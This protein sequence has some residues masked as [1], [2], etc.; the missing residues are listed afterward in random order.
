MEE[1]AAGKGKAPKPFMTGKAARAPTPTRSGIS[2]ATAARCRSERSRQA[3][4]AV[5][6]AKAAAR[7]RPRP[8]R[9]SSRRSSAKLVDRPPA[10]AGWAHEIK[11]DGY[12][13][14]LRVEDGEATL[15]TRKGL[16]WTDK[17]RRHRQRGESAA[18]LHHRRRDRARSTT[19]A[20][21]TSPP[22]RRRSPSGKTDD[23]VFFVFDLLFAD[24]EDL[25]ALPLRE[26]KARLQALLDGDAPKQ[27]RIRYVEHFE[28]G[29]DAVLQ[30][31]C[32]MSLEGIVSKR[33]ERPIAPAAATTGRKPS[34]APATRW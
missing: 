2:N 26:R 30:S 9:T 31:A 13:L 19:T 8:C 32:R 29:G 23:L 25:R 34:A 12:R 6:S 18:R 27:R 24:G 11:F 28:T 14:Q 4:K 5:A 21:P 33:L 1:I 16:D 7:R 15:R 22:C 20:R 3:S 10:G 17:F